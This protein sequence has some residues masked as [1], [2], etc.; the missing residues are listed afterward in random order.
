MKKGSSPFLTP[1]SLTVFCLS[2]CVSSRETILAKKSAYRYRIVVW[3]TTQA[4][5][6]HKRAILYLLFIFIPLF[7]TNPRY[8][9]PFL[10]PSTHIQYTFFPP[11]LENCWALC[12]GWIAVVDFPPTSPTLSPRGPRSSQ[13]LLLVLSVQPM[14]RPALF[15][16]KKKPNSLFALGFFLKGIAPGFKNLLV[17][18]LDPRAD[19]CLFF[20]FFLVKK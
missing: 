14:T 9:L 15:C 17:V 19:V 12:P 18:L 2:A 11:W 13:Q 10:P 7:P 3:W 1:F 4:P 6:S 5:P 8:A 20:L 16:S